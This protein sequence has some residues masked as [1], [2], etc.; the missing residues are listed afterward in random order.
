MCNGAIDRIEVWWNV[1][2]FV[3]FVLVQQVLEESLF[4]A[5]DQADDFVAFV[6]GYFRLINGRTL[7]VAAIA[8]PMNRDT[9][10]NYSSFDAEGESYFSSFKFSW[11]YSQKSDWVE[12][13]KL[14]AVKEGI[15]VEYSQL[16]KWD[17]FFTGTLELQR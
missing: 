11:V 17:T 10:N 15:D 5:A 8:P 12:D 13:K 1:L 7:G 16:Q 4:I 3:F 14:I 9:N 2:L 6:A